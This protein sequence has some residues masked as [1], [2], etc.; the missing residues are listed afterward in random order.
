M[1]KVAGVER[2]YI[3]SFKRNDAM[4]EIRAVSSDT[5]ITSKANMSEGVSD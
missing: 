2:T 5:A 1:T 3:L 4:L